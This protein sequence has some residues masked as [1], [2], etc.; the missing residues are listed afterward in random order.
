[1]ARVKPLKIAYRCFFKDHEK[2][3]WVH[4]STAKLWAD[5][6]EM[7]DEVLFFPQ[8]VKYG[9]NRE[10]YYYKLFKNSHQKP[11]KIMLTLETNYTLTEG[12]ELY[13]KDRDYYLDE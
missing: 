5:V 9:Q 3:E 13:D 8:F 10:N 7:I 2:E 4:Y 12:E 11:E 6:L 1:M